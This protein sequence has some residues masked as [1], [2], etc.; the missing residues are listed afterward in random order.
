MATILN[1]TLNLIEIVRG[2]H[3][4]CACDVHHRLERLHRIGAEII[5]L[6][7][8]EVVVVA[9]QWHKVRLLLDL[10]DQGAGIV[11]ALNS[12]KCKTT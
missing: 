10:A 9:E 12:L 7:Q 1:A 11:P 8:H 6:V 5:H 2:E 4:D 3:E